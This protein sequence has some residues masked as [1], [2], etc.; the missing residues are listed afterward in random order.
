[1]VLVA[2]AFLTAFQAAQKS[3]GP[4]QPDRPNFTNGTNIVPLGKTVV[5]MGYRQTLDGAGTLNDY[6]DSATVRMPFSARGEVR[7]GVPSYLTQLG[8]HAEGF[9]DASIGMKLRFTDAKGPWQPSLGALVT[10]T[11]PSGSA[12]FREDHAQPEIRALAS[13]TFDD[14]SGLDANL[15]YG[16]PSEDG[17]IYDRFALSAAYGRTLDE[18]TGSFAELYTV[19]PGSY[20]GPNQSYADVGLSR[21]LSNDC[22]VDLFG[23]LGLNGT[24][25][26]GFF[27][28]GISFRF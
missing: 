8:P 17:R 18:K 9:G 12:G 26:D 4:I 7:I 16:R 24:A 23:G 2:Y 10:T 6:G 21:L 22:Q 15:V 5:E 3:L 19:L 1:M 20:R 11:L 25:R 13:F 14:K 27:G 28:G